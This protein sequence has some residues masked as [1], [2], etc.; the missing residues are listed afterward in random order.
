MR[1]RE[2][3]Y[4]YDNVVDIIRCKIA[5]DEKDN[6][7]KYWN[8]KDFIDETNETSFSRGRPIVVLTRVANKKRFMELTQGK[9]LDR[10]KYNYLKKQKILDLKE[11]I[12]E[13]IEAS[14]I[15][16]ILPMS[17]LDRLIGGD[18]V[19]INSCLSIRGLSHSSCRR[20]SKKEALDSYKIKENKKWVNFNPNDF[21][22]NLLEIYKERNVGITDK[23]H[24]K[25]L[26][27]E[28]LKTDLKKCRQKMI[29]LTDAI[30]SYL[31]NIEEKEVPKIR[32]ESLEELIERMIN[33][34]DPSLF[35]LLNT[36]V[37]DER[38]DLTTKDFLKEIINEL[39]N[40]LGISDDRF[41]QWTSEL[42]EAE[43]FE[44]DENDCQSLSKSYLILKIVPGSNE[45]GS[46]QARSEREYQLQ[47]FYL[48]ALDRQPK[49]EDYE[50]LDEII[51][52]H[53]I[54]HNK[55]NFSKQEIQPILTELIERCLSK[56]G[57]SQLVIEC[58][59][60]LELLSINIDCW[61]HEDWGD[62]YQI[63]RHPCIDNIH[64]RCLLRLEQ[65]YEILK[66]RWRE[67]WE[68]VQNSLNNLDEITEKKGIKDCR[69]LFSQNTTL[70]GNLCTSNLE[71]QQKLFRQ[72]LKYGIPI[73]MWSRC[74]KK[75]QHHRQ[76]INNLISQCSGKVK[77][78]PEQV[79]QRRNNAPSNLKNEPENLGH[80]LSLLWEDPYRLPPIS[81]FNHLNE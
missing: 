54:K 44:E 31:V 2:K 7:W 39:K 53:E 70:W 80:H 67:K 6:P 34:G 61:E 21:L 37:K 26:I 73:A 55:T 12:D 40:Q 78:L 10:D 3:N 29:A 1:S 50:S 33:C 56:I 64:I 16:N 51:K 46:N 48:K 11:D 27:L 14:F 41:S 74:H 81:R 30:K 19:N 65:K 69:W 79:K 35:R 49:D 62:I 68:A 13:D 9:E 32:E 42:L 28:K 47:A 5:K 66:K 22:C 17:E 71:Q 76:E 8:R 18:G 77:L 75:E 20:F 58:F 38:L 36:L 63:K 4:F 45:P 57:N 72:I 24:A 60:S 23:N 25:N 52:Q 59:T 43:N 15:N